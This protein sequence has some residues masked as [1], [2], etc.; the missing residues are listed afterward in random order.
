MAG[1]L[2]LRHTVN[3]CLLCGVGRLV[4]GTFKH[5][6]AITESLRRDS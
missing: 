2:N 3:V 5:G 4:F 6:A 1:D